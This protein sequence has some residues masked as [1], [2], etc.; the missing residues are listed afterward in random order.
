M[1]TKFFTLFVALVCATSAFAH[2]FVVDGIYYNILGNGYVEVTYK[3]D[4]ADSWDEYSGNITIPQKVTYKSVTYY[5]ISIRNYAFSHCPS[6]TEVT[7]PYSV[8]SI[9]EGAFKNCSSLS[10][11]TI[12]KNVTTIGNRAFYG[13]S[14][15]TAI[16]I[17]NSVTTI[18]GEAFYG[19]S[20]LAEV[21]IPNSV[22][23]I[24]YDAFDDCSSLA[25]ITIPNSVRSIGR[26]AFS[27]CS[28]LETITVEAGNQTYHSSGNCI[29][30]TD[31]KTLHTGCK[32]STIPTDGSVTSI[33]GEA[34]YGCSSLTE[35]IIP[36]NVTSIA[37]N[38]FEDCSSLTEITI[39]NSVTFIDGGAF[40]GCSSL[41]AIT[42]PDG[43]T[44][45]GFSSNNRNA[46]MYCSSLIAVTW[47]AKNCKDF[48]SAV[49]APFYNIRS[50]ITS[51]TFGSEVEY[52][53][54][55]LCSDMSSLTSITIPNS[56]TSIGVNAFSRCSNLQSVKIEAINP[57]TGNG[58][59]PIDCKISVP[60]S[61]LEA[62]QQ[63]SD[64]KKYNLQGF[65]VEYTISVTSEN[66]T[67]GTAVV[68][69]WP[70]CDSDSDIATIQA[71]AQ[72][73]YRF[74][75]WNDGNTDNP[76]SITV[77]QDTTFTATF[78]AVNV[79]A[80]T[81]SKTTLQLPIGAT[82]QLV[83]TVVPEDALNK[84]VT[85]SSSNAE[86]VSVVN[87]LVKAVSNGT[88]TITATSEDGG[89]TA[90]CE[91]IVVGDSAPNSEAITVCFKKPD[92]WS[93]VY[94]YAWN[95]NEAHT[96]V[97]EYLGSW[98]GTQLTEPDAQGWYS[99]T[100]DKTL[101]SVNFI[102]NSGV[103]G[104]QT[105]DLMT[106]QSVCYEWD[107]TAAVLVD[108]PEG[109]ATAVENVPADG[110]SSVRKVLENGTIY[111]LRNGERYTVD[112][113]KVN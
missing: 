64:W 70:S 55:A 98:P 19:C 109:T 101:T 2:D 20:S 73:G 52:I 112:G 94:L 59:L 53:P 89:F 56:V 28:S 103:G 99:Y 40:Y 5:I 3:G 84:N 111:I 12:G 86:V 13:C 50:Q 8:R 105:E 31:T 15:L 97:T 39:P 18:G 33:G 41:T 85:W 44:S 102:F 47:N 9:N 57:P 29:I 65:A 71:T 88:A 26:R 77:T 25:E 17:P 93:K 14:S 4:Y 43:I 32:N 110:V 63:H 67:Q 76:R 72:A 23:T 78:A 54:A 37:Y 108:C 104:V 45:I 24:G 36:N 68:T 69:Q 21:T 66:T 60:C 22:T 61:A 49:S 6:L 90:T 42:I 48:R 96:V 7:I 107:G 34:F 35:I 113:R 82:H 79:L 100:F 95:W 10:S 58:S 74:V 16:T 83:A 38:A 62:Y 1:K 46:F 81:L 92:D 51:F 80:I 106:T 75:A 30:E 87:G 27:G 11:V 91:V